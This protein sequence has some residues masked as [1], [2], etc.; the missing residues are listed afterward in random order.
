MKIEGLD[1]MDWLHKTRRE[2]EQERKRLGLSRVEWLKRMEQE[3]DRIR[4]EL[5]D[6]AQLVASDKPQPGK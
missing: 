6:S 3:A 2:S 1:W 5:S 4:A